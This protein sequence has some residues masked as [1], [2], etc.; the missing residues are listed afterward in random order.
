MAQDNGCPMF[1]GGHSNFQIVKP[2]CTT[3]NQCQGGQTCDSGDC[4][5][6]GCN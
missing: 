1:L 4:T 3:S 2:V 5:T 6:I